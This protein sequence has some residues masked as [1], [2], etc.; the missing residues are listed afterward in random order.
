M[1]VARPA[2]TF[3]EARAWDAEVG[4]IGNR[5]RVLLDEG[6][7]REAWRALGFTNWSNCLSALAEKHG[8]TERR[9]WQLHQANEIQAAL[10]EKISVDGMIPDSHLRPLAQIPA[11]Q[12]P[13][14]WERIVETAKDGNVT[15]AHAQAVVNEIRSPAGPVVATPNG[16]DGS[17]EPATHV[18][19]EDG[20]GEVLDFEAWHCPT[21][22]RHWPVEYL[23]CPY[24][25]PPARSRM[26]VHYSSE[27]DEHYTPKEIIA[28]VLE[29]LGATDTQWWRRLRDYPVC[30]VEG[31]LVFAGNED[32]APFPSAI[33][34]LGEN[35]KQFYYAL[36]ELGDIWQRL[37]LEMCGQT[38]PPGELEC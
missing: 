33:F 8:F 3:E 35:I 13:E 12:R 15:A 11:E 36:C 1:T 34:Y 24:C 21:C 27:T 23:V 17:S 25:P 38:P 14:A 7:R 18:C 4:K 32:G 19:A 9:L 10:T 31:R 20:C 5:L 22:H 37:E 2:M 29:C 28:A 6:Y 26:A 30:L 16:G